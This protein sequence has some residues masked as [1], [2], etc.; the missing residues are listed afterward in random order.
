MGGL[1]PQW[2]STRETEPFG[3][4]CL[5]RRGQEGVY[6][7]ILRQIREKIR[8]NAYVM[9][10]HAEEEMN[11]EDLGIFDVERIILTGSIIERQRDANTKEFKY[12]IRGATL[13]D[14]EGEVIVK[15]GP[16]GK[17]VIITLYAANGERNS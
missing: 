1:N 16:G 2:F 8:V 13:G 17:L 12:R 15:M 7:H 10:I 5:F 6:A 3:V 9:T 4:C 14:E 11:D